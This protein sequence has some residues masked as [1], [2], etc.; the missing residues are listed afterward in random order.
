MKLKERIEFRVDPP[1]KRLLEDLARSRGLSLG[2][3]LRGLVEEQ[4]EALGW[5][6]ASRAQAAEDL[7][8]LSVGR[9]PDPDELRREITDAFTQGR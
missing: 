5:R 3:L 6:P 2:E 1:T 8:R 9:L 7:L 4:L